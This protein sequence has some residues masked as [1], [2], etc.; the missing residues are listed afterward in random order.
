[1]ADKRFNLHNMPTDADKQVLRDQSK[2]NEKAT[3][4]SKKLAKLQQ[5]AASKVET[6]RK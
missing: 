1:M 4:R 6:G 3:K 2:L 5:D